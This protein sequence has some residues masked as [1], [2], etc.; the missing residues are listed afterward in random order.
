M[1]Y[2]AK[3]DPICATVG[4]T[5]TLIVPSRYGGIPAGLGAEIFVYFAQDSGGAGLAWRGIV[6]RISPTKPEEL[7]V[8]ALEAIGECKM[9]NEQL[10]P[11]RN[12][13]D[14]SPISEIA[15]KFYR[16]SH[17]KIVEL[18]DEEAAYLRQYF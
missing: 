4:S 16:H 15:R 17:D 14:G 13:R 1:S 3:C 7:V 5:L 2:M 12:L 18:S 8:R 10:A 9:A 11:Y 6:E